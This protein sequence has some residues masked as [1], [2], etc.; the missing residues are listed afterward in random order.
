MENG[1]GY[2]LPSRLKGLGERPKLPQ[3]GLGKT[4]LVHP[5]GVIPSNI[6]MNLTHTDNRVFGLPHSE[7]RMILSLF[8]WEQ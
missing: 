5:Y 2:P 8:I 3:W 1:E 6:W 4:N 7:D